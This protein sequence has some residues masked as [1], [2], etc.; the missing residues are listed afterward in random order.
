MTPPDLGQS[1]ASDY[2]PWDR[3]EKLGPPPWSG[4]DPK[5]IAWEQAHGHDVRL[6]CYPELGCQLVEVRAERIEAAA[7]A[8]VDMLDSR[9]VGL[10]EGDLALVARLR[11]V[12]DA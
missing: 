4:T 2:R 11:A 12:L 7:R 1:V 10:D 3:D 8:V 9:P 5:V 6:K